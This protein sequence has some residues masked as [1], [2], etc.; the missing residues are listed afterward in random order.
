MPPP[1]EISDKTGQPG[2]GK[3]ARVTLAAKHSDTE[4]MSATTWTGKKSITVAPERP[5]PLVTD[6]QDAILKVTSTAICGSDLHMY[7]GAMP[8]MT[9][10]DVMGH[11][12][13]GIVESVGPEVT[14]FKPG[15]RVV[16]CFDIGCGT[17]LYC[18]KGQYSACDVTN[19]S[20]EQRKLYGHNTA[21][22][23]GYSQLT[24]GW[25]GGQADYARVVFADTNLLKVPDE[26]PDDKYL[27]MS[28]ILPTAWHANELAEVSK[29]DTVAIWGAGPVGALAAQCAWFRGADR[30]III[31]AF[32]YRLKLAQQVAPGTEVI[33]FREKNAVEAIKELVPNGPDC[34]LECVGF[35]YTS[36]SWLHKIE[37][38]L[39]L[40]TDPSSMLNE[41]ITSV[42][43]GGRIGVVGVYAGF[44]NHFNIGAFMEKG[45]KMGAGQTPCQ[46]YWNDLLK[47]TKEGKLKPD[48]VITHHLPLSEAAKGYK[49]FNDKEDDCLKVVLQTKHFTR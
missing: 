11:E 40:E 27:F 49:I 19:P 29:G 7:V 39:M 9:K 36:N 41:L 43:K 38:A 44:T 17:C 8:G 20:D 48:A 21:G 15:D 16:A 3:N 22:I 23:H 13:M 2:I 31:D 14:K 28:D 26:G 47:W 6:P 34:V 10:G 12:F 33:N 4:T 1:Q 32:P 46:A 24:G 42:R 25:E 5:K 37:M 18:N 30:V 35:H 45:L